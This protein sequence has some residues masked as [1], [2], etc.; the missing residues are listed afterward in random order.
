MLRR[1]VIQNIRTRWHCAFWRW[2]RIA[3]S[4]GGCQLQHG[5]HLVATLGGL[6]T[7]HRAMQL[8]Q[9]MKQW[10]AVHA[11]GVAHRASLQDFKKDYTELAGHIHRMEGQYSR[12][13]I[14]ASLS[15]YQTVLAM[16][17]LRAKYGAWVLWIRAT[18]CKKAEIQKLN[19]QLNRATRERVEALEELEGLQLQ[20]RA[21]I[22]EV[23]L[24]R[25]QLGE[26]SPAEAPAST[27]SPSPELPKSTSR[28]QAFSAY[29]ASL[30]AD[31]GF[32]S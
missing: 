23:Q 12:V 20:A 24:L 2:R 29:S 9:A 10:V 16:W 22:K 27:R 21:A 14:G 5:V 3:D 25:S 6:L 4:R 15:K 7:S 19:K 17:A 26:Q 1:C 32:D 18:S 11:A 8:V 28:F 30:M 31:P 13:Q